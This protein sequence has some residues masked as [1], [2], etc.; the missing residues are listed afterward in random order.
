MKT[1]LI[2]WSTERSVS[3]GHSHPWPLTRFEAQV[4][5]STFLIREQHIWNDRNCSYRSFWASTKSGKYSEHSL[6]NRAFSAWDTE[7]P[8]AEFQSSNAE[9]ACVRTGQPRI[10]VRSFLT[11]EIGMVLNFSTSRFGIGGVTTAGRPGPRPTSISCRL[12]ALVGRVP[13]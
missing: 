7:R 12:G 2:N 5:V 10:A 13:P 11:A 6:Q 8:S 3:G 1:D 4:Y 9:N